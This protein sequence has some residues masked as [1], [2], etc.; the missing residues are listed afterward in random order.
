MGLRASSTATL[1]FDNC[2]VPRANLLGNP[3]D[4]LKILFA[5]PNKSRPSVA[6]HAL[7]IARGAFEEMSPTLDGDIL[8]FTHELGAMRLDE[9]SQAME[10]PTGRTP[11]RDVIDTTFPSCSSRIPF[12]MNTNAM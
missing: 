2:R 7:G 1:A 6:A 9:L 5:S 4:G 10:E 3:G 12:P 11:A 8:R